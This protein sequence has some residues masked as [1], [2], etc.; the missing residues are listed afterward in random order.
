MKTIYFTLLIFVSSVSFASN[1]QIEKIQTNKLKSKFSV[2]GTV[3]SRSFTGTQSDLYSDNAFYGA[4]LS[5][6][7]NSHTA[8]Q[9]AYSTGTHDVNVGIN[10][11]NVFSGST[12]ISSLSIQGKYFLKSKKY[13]PKFNP[14]ALFGLSQFERSTQ[15]L[16]TSVAAKD[17]AGGFDLGVGFEMLF[18]EKKNFINVQFVYNK[19]D[20]GNENREI[21]V[22]DPTTGETLRTGRRPNGDPLALQVGFGIYF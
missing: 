4:S 11:D 12:N 16:Q 8:L 2:G 1:E 7:I 10:G 19:V 21:M 9:L 15:G 18:N 6:L 13:N 3:G 14:Y 17:S 5:Y 22:A 20:F